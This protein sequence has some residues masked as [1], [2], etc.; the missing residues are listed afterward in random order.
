MN[1]YLIPI[2]DGEDIYIHNI[3]ARDLES[4]EDKLM[5]ELCEEYDELNPDILYFNEFVND[6]MSQ[7]IWIGDFYDKET[8]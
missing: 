1:T 4:A 7:G 3:T 2:F 6:A 5:Q 8:F